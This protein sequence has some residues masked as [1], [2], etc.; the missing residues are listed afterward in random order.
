MPLA[1]AEERN[2]A[3]RATLP[4]PGSL[5]EA[6]TPGGHEVEADQGTSASSPSGLSQGGAEDDREDRATLPTLHGIDAG[7]PPPAHQDEAEPGTSASSPSGLGHGAGAEE[8]DLAGRA[9]LPAPG[10]SDAEAPNLIAPAGSA[11]ETTQTWVFAATPGAV[12]GG[13]APD[14]WAGLRTIADA[15]DALTPMPVDPPI[16]PTVGSP[17][18]LGQSTDVGQGDAEGQATLPTLSPPSPSQDD[19]LAAA[20]VRTSAAPMEAPPLIVGEDPEGPARESATPSPERQWPPLTV[21]R[22]AVGF[23]ISDIAPIVEQRAVGKADV[24]EIVGGSALKNGSVGSPV[25]VKLPRGRAMLLTDSVPGTLGATDGGRIDIDLVTLHDGASGASVRKSPEPIQVHV[26]LL[27]R[28]RAIIEKRE[29]FASLVR[30]ESPHEGGRQPKN[31]GVSRTAQ[32]LGIS[33]K[34]VRRAEDIASVCDHPELYRKLVEEG[35]AENQSVILELKEFPYKQRV[36]ELSKIIERKR[37]PRQRKPPPSDSSS[38]E[39]SATAEGAAAS[40]MHNSATASCHEPEDTSNNVEP[41]AATESGIAALEL[42]REKLGGSFAAFLEITRGIDLNPLL[43]EERKA[44]DASLKKESQR[45]E[46]ISQ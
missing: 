35:L 11:T 18:S 22:E 17:F 42:L 10:P 19:L 36:A 41:E 7:G 43:E 8:S 2:L 3:G 37:A 39:Y 15:E 20:S 14:G 25:D 31:R 24:T 4:T 34:E 26:S 44:H 33:P 32:E 1:G 6:S 28:S 21:R 46:E 13:N 23:R 45:A 12:V 5:D 9:T 30:E 27:Q 38:K 40:A 29:H 16:E